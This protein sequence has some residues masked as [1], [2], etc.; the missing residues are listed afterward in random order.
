MLK[1][2]DK[3]SL[4]RVVII[5][6]LVTALSGCEA[7]RTMDSFDGILAAKSP[8]DPEI[9]TLARAESAFFEGKYMLAKNLFN[10]V[11]RQSDKPQYINQAYYGLVC[12]SIIH[13]EGLDDMKKAFAMMAKW[14]KP[15][16]DVQGYLE[17]P[18]M[19]S[20][21]LNKKTG[22]LNCENE[23]KVITAKK[24]TVVSREQQEEIEQLKNTI[25]K[26]EHQISVL[27]AIDLEIQEKRKPL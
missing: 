25:K 22:L 3:I 9:A 12:I 27:E 17:N 6:V 8:P 10:E 19:M 1:I 5:I 26:L 16:A 11:K 15:G 4:C 24:K 7:L 18:Q 20:V 23:I 21:A 14:Q 13:A 2:F